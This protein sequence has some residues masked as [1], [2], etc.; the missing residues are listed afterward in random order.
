MSP[1]KKR[2]QRKKNKCFVLNQFF[3]F[4][5]VSD[6][7]NGTTCNKYYLELF[8]KYILDWCKAVFGNE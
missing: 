7:N 4:I 2:N 6:S 1:V 3:G 5:T 8:S